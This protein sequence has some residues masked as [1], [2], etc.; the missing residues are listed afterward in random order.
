[1]EATIR[2]SIGDAPAFDL[3][4][5]RKGGFARSRKSCVESSGTTFLGPSKLRESVKRNSNAPI[6]SGGGA[7]DQSLTMSELKNLTFNTKTTRNDGLTRKHNI[8]M[9]GH[10]GH[11][12]SL[13]HSIN[14]MNFNYE[15]KGNYPSI[16]YGSDI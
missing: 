8:A 5:T 3:S 7:V 1:M 14:F 15:G 6:L 16:G 4:P 13:S 2:S 10:V 11:G 9:D 12:R